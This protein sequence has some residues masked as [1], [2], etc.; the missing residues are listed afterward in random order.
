MAPSASRENGGVQPKIATASDYYQ[1]ED[2]KAADIG[3]SGM[4][5]P[6]RAADGP[7]R[8][9]WMTYTEL[10]VTTHFSFLRGA[11]SAESFRAKRRARHPCPGC[12]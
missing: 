1:V 4:R 3:S 11:S 5:L 6:R 2:D 8:A 9:I 10:Q 12:R 7:S